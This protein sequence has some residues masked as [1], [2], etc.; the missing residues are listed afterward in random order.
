MKKI[1]RKISYF[2]KKA[3]WISYNF[4]LNHW[5]FLLL[6]I[7]NFFII[8]KKQAW[9]F[10]LFLCI[11]NAAH[12]T[13][14]PYNIDIW[15]YWFEV[16][17]AQNHPIIE[18]F[19]KLQILKRC[20][21]VPF[22][23]N[24]ETVYSSARIIWRAY[25]TWKICCK[26]LNPCLSTILIRL[27]HVKEDNFR[28]CNQFWWLLRSTVKEWWPTSENWLHW[29]FLNWL[30]MWSALWFNGQ[31][32]QQ[33]WEPFLKN[34]NRIEIKCKCEKM[35]LYLK[36]HFELFLRNYQ[37]NVECFKVYNRSTITRKS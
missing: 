1:Q 34:F 14:H 22:S 19:N 28:C 31:Y 20:S 15:W 17:S 26:F 21:P 37:W 3:C 13:K 10:I 9:F 2:L 6:R 29:M 5:T 33:E 30:T 36:N 4:A 7:N 12:L 35:H 32:F 11:L 8:E 27:I 25:W 23:M 24:H 16:A 18:S